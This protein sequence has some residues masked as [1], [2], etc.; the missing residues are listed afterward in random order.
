MAIFFIRVTELLNLYRIALLVYFSTH[1]T[2]SPLEVSNGLC[3]HA[4]TVFS[5]ARTSSGQIFTCLA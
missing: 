4:S 5:F 3:D 2:L 1:E